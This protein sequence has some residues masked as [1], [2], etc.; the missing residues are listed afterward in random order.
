MKANK[1]LVTLLIILVAA[2]LAA[3]GYY[4]WQKESSP[5]ADTNPT[6]YVQSSKTA[7]GVGEQITASI[8]VDGGGQD[9]TSFQANVALTNLNVVSFTI[10][11]SVQQWQTTP[12][13]SQLNFLGGVYNST[14]SP[15]TVYTLVLQAPAAG[16]ASIA[17]SNGAI[18]QVA[19]DNV[20]VNN[21]LQTTTGA[22]YTVQ[23]APVVSAGADKTAY[24]APV[25]YTLSGS[26]NDASATLAWTKVSGPGTITFTNGTTLTPTVTASLPGIYVLKLTATNLAGLTAS[27]NM[28]L[29][30]YKAGDI[31]NDTHIN[32]LDFTLLLRNW[33]TP[34]NA[35]ADLNNSSP[36]LVNIDDF[37]VL[38]LRWGS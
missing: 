13:A 36:A 31:N 12:S 16:T 21:I 37:T 27:A 17:L 29:T 19:A 14:T 26:A 6:I 23:T 24:P 5:E 32:N 35:M 20:T 11:P 8:I 1:V 28:T 15:I 25:P 9:Y 22:T 18:L 3:I 7:F 30:V 2:V 4:Y 38:M 33:G 10:G 34:V